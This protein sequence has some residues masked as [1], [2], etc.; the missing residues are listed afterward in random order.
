MRLEELSC[1]NYQFCSIQWSRL[2]ACVLSA[3]DGDGCETME[4]CWK[5]C[6]YGY[7]V[8]TT[9][10]CQ[11]CQCVPN[12]CQVGLRCEMINTILIMCWYHA[13]TMKMLCWYYGDIIL[14]LSWYYAD[15]KLILCRYDADTIQILCRCYTDTKLILSWYC[16][17]IMQ[18]D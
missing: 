8:N 16:T 11:M 6:Q 1:M 7:K 14:I 17:H 5:H 2:F 18:G 9:T 4:D 10:H 13:D 12:P 3:L 15:T